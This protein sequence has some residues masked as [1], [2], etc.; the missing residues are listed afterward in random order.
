MR[1][2]EPPR[3]PAR[4]R[5]R[6]PKRRPDPTIVGTLS[7][8]EACEQLGIGTATGYRLAAAAEF[9]VP[10]RLIGRTRKVLKADMARYLET[11]Q[12]DAVGQ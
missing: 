7:I 1:K 11:G 9:P 2:S 4:D 8:A 6:G 3:P 10:V 5:V 12:A